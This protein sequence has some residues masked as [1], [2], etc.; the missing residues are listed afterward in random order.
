M[1]AQKNAN[2]K[3][4]SLSTDNVWIIE[5]WSQR[6]NLMFLCGR[7]ATSPQHLLVLVVTVLQYKVE[8]LVL[9]PSTSKLKGLNAGHKVI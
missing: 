5:V 8:A 1:M 2:R 6:D 9:L 3:S 7:F 4:L